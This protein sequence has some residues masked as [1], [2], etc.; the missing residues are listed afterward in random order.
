MVGGTTIEHDTATTSHIPGS[1]GGSPG[2]LHGGQV[3]SFGKTRLNNG[4]GTKLLKQFN[5]NSGQYLIVVTCHQ[6][7]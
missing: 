6:Q 1:K 2:V 5:K 4:F 3:D 7:L